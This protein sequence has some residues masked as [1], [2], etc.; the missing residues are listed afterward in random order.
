MSGTQLARIQENLKI[1]KLQQIS[2]LLE[3]RLE[4]ASK[5][6]LSYTDFLDTLLS[7][8]ITAKTERNIAMRTSILSTVYR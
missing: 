1:L 2:G 8:E 4:E 7:E 5:Q 6:N 3:T